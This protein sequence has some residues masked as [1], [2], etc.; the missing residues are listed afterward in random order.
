MLNAND[1]ALVL[2][3]VQAKL[4]PAIH[5]REALL[6]NLSRLLRGAKAL[7]VPVVATEQNPAGLG[8]T[9]PELAGLLE[10]PPIAKMS[11]GCCGEPAFLEA[12]S[13]LGRRSIL[14]AGIEAH[15]CVYQTVAGLLEAGYEVQVVA[16]GVS[17]R[18]AANRDLALARMAAAGAKITS[19]EMALF[20]ML[21][22]AEGSAFKQILQIVK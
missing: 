19:V 10:G 14:A 13:R 16:D 9:V 20:E 22:A 4:L 8:P 12:L 15:V 5:E 1:T 7:G 11:F 2:I 3:D 6:D 18:K 21:G 17:S